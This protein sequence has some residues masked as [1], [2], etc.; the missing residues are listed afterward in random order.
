MRTS[1]EGIKHGTRIGKSWGAGLK[2]ERFHLGD[3]GGP[4]QV[5]YDMKLEIDVI[6]NLVITEVANAVAVI[7]AFTAKDVGDCKWD[8]TLISGG[9]RASRWVPGT[10]GWPQELTEGICGMIC[11]GVAND[12]VGTYH[13]WHALPAG[14]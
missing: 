5:E 1:V 9:C 14:H 8:Y 13:R 10:W 11:L 6:G 12:C 3:F 4:T 2:Y 7:N